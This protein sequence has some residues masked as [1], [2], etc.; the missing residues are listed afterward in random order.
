[1]KSPV[2]LKEMGKNKEEKKRKSGVFL[3]TAPVCPLIY[4]T[5]QKDQ[6]QTTSDNKSP[7][8]DISMSLESSLEKPKKKTH[9]KKHLSEQQAENDCPTEQHT[10]GRQDDREKKKKKLRNEDVRHVEDTNN[11]NLELS[12]STEEPHRKKKKR[13]K[14][15][16]V[17]KAEEL[18][19]QSNEMS[20]EASTTNIEDLEIFRDTEEPQRK[21]KKR[22]KT[23]EVNEAEELKTQSNEMSEEASPKK[24]KKLKG[25]NVNISEKAIKIEEVSLTVESETQSNELKKSKK[26]N[27]SV[28]KAHKK[29][30]SVSTA[31]DDKKEFTE[32]D[33]KLLNEL[34]EF[35]PDIE[36]KEPVSIN[37]MIKYDL[38]RFKEFRE[39]GIALNH[40]RFT[41]QENERL[42]KNVGDF[43]ALTAVDSATKLFFT[44]RFKQEQENIKKLKVLHKFFERIGIGGSV[45]GYSPIMRKARVRFQPMPQPQPLDTVLVPSP[46]KWEGCVRKGIRRK[47]F[48]K[49]FLVQFSVETPDCL[50][51][52]AVQQSGC[53]GPNA[54]GLA[55]RGSAIPKPGR[56]VAAQD[57]LDGLSVEG[58]QDERW[59]MSL[60]QPSQE[61]E[62]L[63]C[64]LA[65]GIPRSCYYVY[66]RGRRMFDEQNHQGEFSKAELHMLSKLHTLHGNNWKKISELTGRSAFS[67]QKRYTQIANKEGPWSKKEV[68]RLLRAVRDYIVS[69]IPGAANSNGP[70]R[71]MKETLY[72]RLPLQKIA[73]KVKTRSWSQCREKWMG[74]LAV[75]MSFGAVCTEKKSLDIQVKLIKGMYEMDVDDAAHV[76]WEDLT[77]LIGD[78]PPAY[79]QRKWHKLKVCHVPEW[80]RKCFGDIVDF[81]Y[82]KV[83]PDLQNKLMAYEDLDETK[84]T[85]NDDESYLLSDIFQDINEDE[86][87]DD[88]AEIHN[89]KN[90]DIMEEETQ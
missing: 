52:E 84:H 64:F 73:K 54:S 60:P 57:A 50:R 21:K 34:K 38:P 12:R 26:K 29:V 87:V 27:K 13:E 58:G 23:K 59:K 42:R 39:Q 78:V 41:A 7:I 68:Q 16:E 56:D 85:E 86:D 15:K 24:K 46:E 71:V 80:Q 2:K 5:P 28:E 74:I 8:T 55:I 35:I 49:L 43:M 45:V 88:E 82:E 40:G 90:E 89:D 83:L 9:K 69:Q 61:V 66:A 18:E 14:T 70:V 31:K 32:I 30:Q 1:M 53:E 44:H 62:T 3:E 37:K 25:S 81:L 11:E 67:L 6:L 10:E 77:A 65:E 47:T 48:A 36:S 20:E 51:K 75:K 63:L 33:A 17:N 72:K 19:M 4:E 79:V 76:N 22:E